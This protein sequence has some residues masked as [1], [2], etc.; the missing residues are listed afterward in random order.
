MS[1][2]EDDRKLDK[3]P[4]PNELNEILIELGIT[5]NSPQE[6]ILLFFVNEVLPTVNDD[7]YEVVNLPKLL[8]YLHELRSEINNIE[9]QF[10]PP[11]EANEKYIFALKK[12]HEIFTIAIESII[13][14]Y[15]IADSSEEIET[16]NFL[17]TRAESKEKF[18]I[19][20]SLIKAIQIGRKKF[21]I[22]KIYDDN[23]NCFLHQPNTKVVPNTNFLISQ[24]DSRLQI[25]SHSYQALGDSPLILGRNYLTNQFV[26][27][28]AVSRNHVSIVISGDVPVITDL[29]SANGTHELSRESMQILLSEVDTK[30]KPLKNQKAET[31]GTDNQTTLSESVRHLISPSGNIIAAASDKGI[32]YKDH[33]E[34]RV[35]VNPEIE[36]YAVVDGMGGYKN[37]DVAAQIIADQLLALPDNIHSAIEK[38]S[39]AIDLAINQGTIID[40]NSGAVFISAKIN[41]SAG[42]IDLEYSYVGDCA[43]IVLNNNGGV[44]HIGKKD[45]FV[46]S[47]VEMEIITPDE[48]L[49]HPNRSV[50][51]KQV[52]RDSKDFHTE[53]LQISV[54]DRVILMSDGIDDNFT[55][56]EL[57]IIVTGRTAMDAILEIDRITSLRMQNGERI[58]RNTQNRTDSGVFSDGYKSE[59]KCDNRSIIIIDIK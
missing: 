41:R 45:S 53:K 23:P 43:L 47:M 3:E 18:G 17:Y 22:F 31:I 55:P 33:N 20:G 35:V 42:K 6:K 32:L 16:N 51:I 24:F 15:E 14:K 40:N 59:P 34:D 11:S 27:D 50:V 12:F 2:I 58:V 30:Y 48:A 49:Y 29:G 9:T 44:K 4:A 57:A 28:A 7:S 52:D 26:Y 36:F 38:A 10:T 5:Q 46:S 21:G 1:V 37:G 39:N 13:K 25:H 8:T 19:D 56:Q 54:G